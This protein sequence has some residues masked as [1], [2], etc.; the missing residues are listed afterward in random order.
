[1]SI[2]FER[3]IALVQATAHD[4]GIK[5]L[6]EH[7]NKG[8]STLY[9]EL[10]Q[11]EGYKLGAK[12][13]F[14]VIEKTGDISPLE[15]LLSDMGLA[16]FRLPVLTYALNPALPSLLLNLLGHVNKECSDTFGATLKMVED[17]KVERK[18]AV[19]GSQECMDAINALVQLKAQF[20]AIKG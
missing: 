17:G 9:A 3:S 16:V 20:D 1:M 7:L 2:N 12:E 10:N 15:T 5:E 11:N 8:V 18:E 6:A 13:F 4:Y 14:R 19:K